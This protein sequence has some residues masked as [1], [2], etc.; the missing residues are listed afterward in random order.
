LLHVRVSINLIT[1]P[2]RHTRASFPPTGRT[3]THT[4]T[5]SRKSG[6]SGGLVVEGQRQKR[7]DTYPQRV[8]SYCSLTRRGR[9]ARSVGRRRE[10][11][12][13]LVPLGVSTGV[14]AARP[15]AFIYSASL[16]WCA[17][18]DQWTNGTIAPRARR[19]PPAPHY[20]LF[21]PQ[22]KCCPTCVRLGRLFVRASAHL[23]RSGPR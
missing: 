6:S 14:S 16:Q 8:A 2:E 9:S 12:A 18:T 1:H 10:T 13:S 5:G 20:H 17:C 19:Q 15:A 21:L 23:W 3:R 4:H 11:R 7:S 22:L